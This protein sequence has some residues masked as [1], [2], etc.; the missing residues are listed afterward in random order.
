MLVDDAATVNTPSWYSKKPILATLLTSN[1]SEA[2]VNS[3]EKP[4]L[5]TLLTSNM[6]GNKVVGH[7]GSEQQMKVKHQNVYAGKGAIKCSRC[8]ATFW[9]NSELSVHMRRHTG[10]RPFQCH[11]CELALK[12][13]GNLTKHLQCIHKIEEPVK[14]NVAETVAAAKSG[15][16]RIGKRPY[17]R[18]NGSAPLGQHGQPKVDAVHPTVEAV[19]VKTEPDSSADWTDEAEGQN[20]SFQL[21]IDDGPCEGKV[22]YLQSVSV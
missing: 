22:L 10:E 4:I 16:Y 18:R 15:E 9:Y 1:T 7:G 5:A 20:R 17:R 13:R 2:A 11:L 14:A 19:A 8:P 3:K 21:Q 12:T 6:Y